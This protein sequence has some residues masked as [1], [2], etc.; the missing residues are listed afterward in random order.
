MIAQ[1]EAKP[2]PPIRA[3]FARIGVRAEKV[4]SVAF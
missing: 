3:S 1:D 2:G 4:A